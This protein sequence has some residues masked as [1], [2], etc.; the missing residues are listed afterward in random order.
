MEKFIVA[1]IRRTTREL[2]RFVVRFALGAAAARGIRRYWFVVVLTPF[3]LALEVSGAVLR[4]QTI[5]LKPGWNAVFLEVQP[6][7]SKPAE[8]FQGLAIQTVAC[9]VP[10]SLNEQYLR[11]PGDAPWRQEGWSVWHAPSQP[12]A[13]LSNLYSI[14]AHRS[15]LIRATES[16]TWTVTGTPGAR[17]IEWFPNTCTFTGLPVDP[18]APPT[19]KDF[20]AGCEAHQRLRIFRLENGHWKLVRDPGTERARH[21]EAYWIQTDGASAWQGPLRLNLPALGEIDFDLLGSEKFIEFHNDGTSVARIR[22]EPI[23]GSE[24]VP[25]RIVERNLTQ[26]VTEFRDFPA[27]LDLPPL[28]AASTAS[29][30][31]SI[32]RTGLRSESVS[33][34]LK[35]SDGRGTVRWVPMHARRGFVAAQ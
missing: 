23:Y 26:Q 2:S 3:F 29:L 28:A 19:F 24:P 33:T 15:Y 6:A 13:F 17:P 14:Q 11:T 27:V 21:G 20:F 16:V 8:L 9:F 4:T 35:I 10:G 30:K 12:E 34:L 22:V 32:D 18:D 1:G 7:A 31:I 25:L 5:V